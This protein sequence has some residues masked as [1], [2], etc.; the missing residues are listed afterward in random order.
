M[1]NLEG[2]LPLLTFIVAAFAAVAFT[3]PKEEDPMYG[4]D[5]TYWYL[6]DEDTPP[7]SYQCDSQE[8]QNCLFDAIEGSPL[9]NQEDRKF[10]NISLTPIEE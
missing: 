8:E 10:V 4:T 7:G 6:V 3:S 2:K 1:K 9:P 5:G